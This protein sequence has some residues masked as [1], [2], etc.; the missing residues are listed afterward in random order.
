MLQVRALLRS[1]V[2]QGEG[3]CLRAFIATCIRAYVGAFRGSAQVSPPSP[4]PS[5][6]CTDED[7]SVFRSAMYALR[8]LNNNYPS[9]CNRSL[10]IHNFQFDF[11]CTSYIRA[12]VCISKAWVHVLGRRYVHQGV[13]TCIREQVYALGLRYVLQGVGTYIR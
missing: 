7:S 9:N 12:F 1:F 10:F 8:Y 6:F 3:T 11:G 5:E 2:Y 4:P 13:G